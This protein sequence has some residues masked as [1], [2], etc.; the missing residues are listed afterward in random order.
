MTD[1]RLSRRNLLAGAAVGGGALLAT[2]L[3]GVASADPASTDG[4]SV[5]PRKLVPGDR[6]R[7]VSPGGPPIHE[8]VDLGKAMLESWGLVVELGDHALGSFGYL[9][10]PDADRLA[11]LNDA[12]ADPDVRAVLATRGGYGTGRIVDGIDYDA[13]RADPKLVLG[14]SDITA[15]HLALWKEAR[16]ATVHGPMIAWNESLNG[17]ITG[18]IATAL[19]AALMTT[20]PTVIRRDP[21]IPTSGVEVAGKATGRL[22]GGNLSLLVQE[23]RRAN[24]PDTA[25]AIIVLE[26]VD[27]EP[28]RVDGMITQLLRDGWFDDVAGVALGTFVNSVGEPGEWTVLD[29][30]ADRLKPLGVPVLGGLP[31]GHDVKP[32]TVPLGTSATLDTKAGTLTV[33]SAAS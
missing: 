27:E 29:V 19:K 6:V 15:L 14:Y 22:L 31:V 33:T 21:A 8:R 1:P 5:R 2:T 23:P 28:Y 16:L 30:L 11:D 18:P 3:P 25:G 26:D 9:S 7:L 12:F 24:A 10:A 32:L 20:A 13:V 17:P 4:R